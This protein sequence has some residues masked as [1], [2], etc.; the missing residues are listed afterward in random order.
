MRYEEFLQEKRITMKC[1]GFDITDVSDQLF[2]F[3]KDM[4][5]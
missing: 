1:T 5:R 2:D 4:V 3:Q